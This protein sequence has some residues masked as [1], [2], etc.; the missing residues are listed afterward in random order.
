MDEIERVRFIEA[1]KREK[2]AE[3]AERDRIKAKLAADRAER[4]FA[5]KEE[6]PQKE[7]T[8][9][10]GNKTVS[11]GPKLRAELRA[12]KNEHGDLKDAA[13]KALLGTHATTVQRNDQ[14]ARHICC[15]DGRLLICC[16]CDVVSAL[17]SVRLEHH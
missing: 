9:F 17:Y 2:E 7:K 5:P 16:S 3:K 10:L 13:F 11:A 14:S 1:K 4:G 8:D 12:I 6:D 15:V